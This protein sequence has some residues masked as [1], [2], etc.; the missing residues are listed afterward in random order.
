LS[1]ANFNGQ[2]RARSI[3]VS[4][5]INK[6]ASDRLP[7]YGCRNRRRDRERVGRGVAGWAGVGVVGWIEVG[8]VGSDMVTRASPGGPSPGTQPPPCRPAG[9]RHQ[10]PLR[11][12]PWRGLWTTAGTPPAGRL[13]SPPGAQAQVRRRRPGSA[14]RTPK[15]KRSRARPPVR[16]RDVGTS[17]GPRTE[18]GRR[19]P[20]RRQAVQNHGRRPPQHPTHSPRRGQ[21]RTR[22]NHDRNSTPTRRIRDPR[23]PTHSRPPHGWWGR[24]R[25]LAQG[26]RG[27]E[28]L[29][30]RG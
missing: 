12:Q 13:R 11:P 27:R 10:P 9:A 2:G 6:E 26:W 1:T 7:L 24:S 16:R 15:R 28:R 4:T 17:S 14:V 25:C 29:R 20:R 3:R 23:R 30:W 22:R 8:V 18:D 21:I 19:Q 5:R